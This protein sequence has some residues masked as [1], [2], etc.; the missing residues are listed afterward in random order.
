MSDEIS[1]DNLKFSVSHQ[2]P[3]K[4]DNHNSDNFLITSMDTKELQLVTLTPNLSSSSSSSSSQQL[5]SLTISSVSKVN[6]SRKWSEK[7]HHGQLTPSISDAVTKVLNGY[8]WTLVTT[9]SKSTSSAKLKIHVK[10]PMNA[11]MVWAQ[12]ARRKLADQYPHLHNAELSKSLGKLWRVLSEEEKKPF[13]EEAERLRLIHKTAHPDYKY[14]PRRRKSGKNGQ[15]ESADCPSSS[16]SSKVKSSSSSATSISSS[17]SSSS[18]KSNVSYETDFTDSS[19]ETKSMKQSA[20]SE[21]KKLTR[22]NNINSKSLNHQHINNSAKVNHCNT[23]N[24]NNNNLST[25][26]LTCNNFTSYPTPTATTLI[27]GTTKSS[28]SSSS[29]STISTTTTSSSL[30]STTTTKST[31]TLVL[32]PPSTPQSELIA[33][34]KPIESRLTKDSNDHHHVINNKRHKGLSLNTINSTGENDQSNGE[35]IVT[36][37]CLVNHNHHHHHQSTS[38]LQFTSSSNNQ[39]VIDLVDS[40]SID[41]LEKSELDQYLPY[42]NQPNGGNNLFNYDHVDHGGGGGGGTGIGQLSTTINNLVTP[43]IEPSSTVDAIYNWSN[44]YISS[45]QQS[46]CQVNY[47]QPNQ[48]KL[49]QCDQTSERSTIKLTSPITNINN[50]AN[51]FTNGLQSTNQVNCNSNNNNQSLSQIIGA[52]L[53]SDCDNYPLIDSFT[54]IKSN[55]QPYQNN[56]QTNCESNTNTNSNNSNY[57]YNNYDENNMFWSYE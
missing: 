12:A 52:G 19:D 56:H 32:T 16:F 5:T 57:N 3:P 34:G 48:S 33:I 14:Q 30:S 18:K 15:S 31:T 8:D 45:L 39:N 17:S 42:Y 9:S 50:K 2:N 13:M 6:G 27:T 4:L 29:S 7:Q 26:S 1:T 24:N 46:T 11:F 55:D 53:R 35:S 22:N 36:V 38:S 10:R 41:N 21:T 40:E 23:N 51:D 54:T 49:T 43:T 37:N 28:S 47:N 25:R 44:H 20:R